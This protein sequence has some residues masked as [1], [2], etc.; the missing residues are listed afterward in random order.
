MRDDADQ[1]QHGKRSSGFTACSPC[2][3]RLSHTVT[4]PFTSKIMRNSP[5]GILFNKTQSMFGFSLVEF[6]LRRVSRRCWKGPRETGL[7]RGRLW[8]PEALEHVGKTI[9]YSQML[10]GQYSSYAWT[11]RGHTNTQLGKALGHRIWT[12]T[13]RKKATGDFLQRVNCVLVRLNM[14]VSERAHVVNSGVCV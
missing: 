10:S 9:S 6:V 5:W 2:L 4:R 12:T 3:V 13:R 8:G 14:W 11:P 1:T 7:L